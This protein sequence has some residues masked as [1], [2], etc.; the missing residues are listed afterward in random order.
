MYIECIYNIYI[1]IYVCILIFTLRYVY[2]YIYIYYKKKIYIHIYTCSLLSASKTRSNG[3]VP[4][5]MSFAAFW[6]VAYLDF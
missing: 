3:V 5:S 4:H 2:I 6:T 1:Y